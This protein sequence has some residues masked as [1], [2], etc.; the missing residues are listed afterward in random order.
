MSASQNPVPKDIEELYS[1]W[2]FLRKSWW[3]CHYFIGIVGVL[4]A[5]TSANKPQ[6]LQT[7]PLLLN[8]V[9]WLAAVCVS[10]LT[11]L[12]PK[13]RARAYTSAWRVLHRAIGTYK[14][15]STLPEATT[16]Y[17][18]VTQGEEIIAKLDG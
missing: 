4:A 12:E 7:E 9:A 17:E 5:I 10:I 13:K 18:A 15:S 3:F 16:L 8:A 1:S 2:V 14:H 11:F 6:F